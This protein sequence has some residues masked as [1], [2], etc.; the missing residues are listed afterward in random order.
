KAKYCRCHRTKNPP[1]R[2]LGA[3]C[4]DQRAN[5][6]KSQ[7]SQRVEYLMQELGGIILRLEEQSDCRECE[8][9][10]QNR[11][12]EQGRCSP[13]H[14]QASSC[15]SR[16]HNPTNSRCIVQYRHCPRAPICS[17]TNPSTMP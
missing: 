7:K 13:V 1:Y 14:C 16:S 17:L 2:V 15:G 5:C 12:W 6:G 8:I 10:N 3:I 9:A 11:P 4:G